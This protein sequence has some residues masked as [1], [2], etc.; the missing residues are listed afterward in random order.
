[1]KTSAG[2]LLFKREKNNLFYFLVHPGG[3]FWKNKDAGAWS[4]PKGEVSPGEDLLERA[5]IEFK[6]ETGQTIEGKFTALQPVKQKGGKMVYAWALEGHME[7]SGLYSNTVQIEWPPRSS[8]II[9]IPEVD[10]WEWFASEEVKIKINSAQAD[11]IMELEKR[12][13]EVE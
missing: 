2:I 6:E 4:I 10:Q 3:P 7:T 9:E 5:L 8:S 1:M 11:F 12:M 13:N